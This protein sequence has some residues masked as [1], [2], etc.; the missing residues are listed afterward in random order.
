MLVQTVV[1]SKD[2][3]TEINGKYC[4]RSDVVERYGNADEVLPKPSQLTKHK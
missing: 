4:E 2:A 3:R 1:E